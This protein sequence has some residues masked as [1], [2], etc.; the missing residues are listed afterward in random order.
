MTIIE[1]IHFPKIKPPISKIGEPKPK[2][3]TQ[4][5]VNK[6]NPKDKKIKLLSLILLRMSVLDFIIS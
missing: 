5:T 3:N 1:P 6:K 2:S 4:T